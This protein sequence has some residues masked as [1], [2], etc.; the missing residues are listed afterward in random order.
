MNK[1][2]FTLVEILLVVVILGIICA[3]TIPNIM[4]SLSES[5]V[6]AGENVEK[7]LLENLKLYTKNNENEWWCDDTA[8]YG[9][10]CKDKDGNKIPVTGEVKVSLDDLKTVNPNIDMKDCVFLGG[11]DTLDSSGKYMSVSRSGNKEEGYKYSY[12]V[13]IKCI[14]KKKE[15]YNTDKKDSY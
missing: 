11:P 9:V 1:K 3:I 5:K 4:E 7:V 10:E 8:G 6:E 15:Y 14:E 2:G 12:T 13:K